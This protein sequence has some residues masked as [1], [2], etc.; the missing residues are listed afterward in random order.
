[1][2]SEEVYQAL[3][4]VGFSHKE[5]EH[6]VK[7]KYND[8]QGFMSKEAILFL[9]A[10]EQG[11]EMIL[12][13]D[14]YT[15]NSEDM[16]DYHEFLVAIKDISEG[17]DNLVIMGKI[18]V[19]FPP[20]EF[21]RKDGSLGRV[22]AFIIEDDTGKIKI[23]LWDAQ[24]EIIDNKFFQKGEIVQVIGAYSKVG[25]NEDLEIHLS[26]KGKIILSPKAI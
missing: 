16:I 10:K 2:N 24:C 7:E 11:L 1:M 3:L 4:K 5:I 12:S 21:T 9:V 20:R 25:L 19:I 15:V 6:Q 22:G 23:T 18:I 14:Q 13:E 17:M 26:R 8:F